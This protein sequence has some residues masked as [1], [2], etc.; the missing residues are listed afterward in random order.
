MA[1]GRRM[2]M[3]QANH[4]INNTLKRTKAKFFT[5]GERNYKY[6]KGETKMNSACGVG[7]ELEKSL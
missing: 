5:I 4:P 6:R 7:L 2:G 3:Y 1:V